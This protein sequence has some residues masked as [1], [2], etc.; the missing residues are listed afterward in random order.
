MLAKVRVM[1]RVPVRDAANGFDFRADI[2]VRVRISIVALGPVLRVSHSHTTC[3][4]TQLPEN[5]YG[6][7]NWTRL[8]K[9]LAVPSQGHCTTA[10]CGE[11]PLSVVHL[12]VRFGL[13]L[14]LGLGNCN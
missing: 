4:W 1:V 14:R 7:D 13:G 8:Q 2:T 3:H 6:F 5:P 11:C 9:H 12:G 10:L